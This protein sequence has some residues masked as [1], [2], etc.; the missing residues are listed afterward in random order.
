[1]ATTPRTSTPRAVRYPT[2]DGKPMAE[3]DTHR[4]GMVDLIQTLQ[5]R[6]AADPMVYVSGNILLFYEEGNPRAHVSP[7]V[8]VV[9]GIAK[10]PVKDNYK[11]WEEGKGPDLVIELTSKS[12]RRVDQT[13]KR[14]LYRDV[15]RV[16]EYIQFDP[17][18]EWLKPP[19]QGFRLVGGEYA[20]IEPVDGRLPSEVLGLHL[21]REGVELRL[22]DPI[23]GRLMT[24][25]ERTAAEQ[26]RADIEQARA[27]TEQA[28]AD[29]EQARADIEQA[30]AEA[31]RRIAEAE[32]GR[33][34]AEKTRADAA[35]AQVARLL[36]EIEAMHRPGGNGA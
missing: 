13:T 36:R 10:L 29:A 2:S 5:V 18:G 9:R 31:E 6:Y 17:F 32:R 27:D 28:R 26:A 3:T 1:M 11:V 23:A 12:T 19:L 16:R 21:G 22:H 25:K 15:L 8:L 24:L 34:E 14:A 4:D 7:D 30:R 20:A 33:A 35:E